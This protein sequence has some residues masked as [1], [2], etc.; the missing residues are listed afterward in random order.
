MVGMGQMAGRGRMVRKGC[1]WDMADAGDGLGLL[2]YNTLPMF[3]DHGLDYPES[4]YNRAGVTRRHRFDTLDVKTVRDGDLIFVKTDALEAF[5]EALEHLS[6]RFG[7]VTAVSATD[8]SPH[9]DLLDD[10]QLISWAGVHLPRWSERVLQIPIGFSERERE[11]GDEAVV[12]ANAGGMDWNARPIDI[13][14]T[15]LAPTSDER[16]DLPLDGVHV[17]GERLCYADYMAMLGRARFV[18]CPRGKGPDTLRFWETL[19]TGGIPIVRTGPLDPLY[20][21]FGGLIIDDWRRLRDAV[22][23]AHR[24]A[25]AV[26]ARCRLAWNR[27]A[28]PFFAQPWAERLTAHHRYWMKTAR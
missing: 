28:A 6:V 24:A 22:A 15:A 8:P 19:V 5:R 3:C 1:W 25:P 4:Y 14:S 10:P 2:R 20:R 7:L 16:R 13:L 27:R 18:I 17:I 23:A 12:A 26:H 9:R 11:H 21:Q